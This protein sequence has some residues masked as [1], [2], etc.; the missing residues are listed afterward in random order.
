MR[1]SVNTQVEI[2]RVRAAST[3]PFD[4]LSRFSRAGIPSE[5]R[6]SSESSR[7]QLFYLQW[8]QLKE[9]EAPE[10]PAQ[11]RQKGEPLRCPASPV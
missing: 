8:Q 7:G 1:V 3:E 4:I 5:A 9:Q 2:P 10:E 6:I 11:D